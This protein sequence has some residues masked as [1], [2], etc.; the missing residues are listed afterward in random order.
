MSLTDYALPILGFALIFNAVY[1]KVKN[2][3]LDK[4]HKWDIAIGIIICGFSIW[5]SVNNSQA[6]ETL[7]SSVNKLLEKRNEDS[8]N[9]S[10]FQ[11]YLK[12]TFGIEKVGNEAKIVNR[13]TYIRNVTINN[14]LPNYA[15]P[16]YSKNFGYKLSKN[17]DTLILFPQEGVWVKPFFAFDASL[18][19]KNSNILQSDGMYQKDSRLPPEETIINGTRYKTLTV[20]LSLVRDKINPLI[21]DISANK[22]QYIIFGDE[23][24]RQKRYIYKNGSVTWVPN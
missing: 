6:A 24:D 18:E 16:N 23:S 9:N 19:E 17:K 1:F 20:H 13:N 12:D 10:H 21:L 5:S 8:A 22:N 3:K 14:T 2:N 15:T 4:K 11:K 7:Q